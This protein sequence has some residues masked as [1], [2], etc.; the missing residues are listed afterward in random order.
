MGYEDRLSKQLQ[1]LMMDMGEAVDSYNG[2]MED[3]ILRLSIGHGFI[4]WQLRNIFLK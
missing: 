3:I 2:R 4:D 1:D